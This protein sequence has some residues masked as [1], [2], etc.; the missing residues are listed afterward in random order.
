MNK[1]LM[2]FIAGIIIFAVFLLFRGDPPM[3]E[4]V[5]TGP[6]NY[7]K[8]NRYVRK[9]RDEFT[10]TGRITP[11]FLP[12]RLTEDQ[13]VNYTY[14]YRCAFMGDANYAITVTV[15]YPEE[16]NFLKEADRIQKLDGFS[17]T[18]ENETVTIIGRRGLYEQLAGFFEAPVSDGSEYVMEYATISTQDRTIT[19][20][21]VR[22][23][24]NQIIQEDI[25]S[26]LALAYE[27]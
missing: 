14:W 22:I 20:S 25:L 7:L 8:T 12:E 21:E 18:R 23:W 26:Q 11:E 1:K 6:E 5:E 15:R 13:T 24:E 3:R 19:Y 2:P 9:L 4:E 27:A 10:Q 17:E 16:E